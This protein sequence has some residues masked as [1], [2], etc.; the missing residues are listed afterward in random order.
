MVRIFNASQ[1]REAAE[2]LVKTQHY[3]MFRTADFKSQWNKWLFEPE[4]VIHWD[5][6]AYEDYLITFMNVNSQYGHPIESFKIVTKPVLWYIDRNG[7]REEFERLDEMLFLE[8][9]DSWREL[10]KLGAGYEVMEDEPQRRR[11]YTLDELAEEL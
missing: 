2:Y 1:V 6:K 4:R 7:G 3:F 9:V 8:G 11:E 10:L 5:V